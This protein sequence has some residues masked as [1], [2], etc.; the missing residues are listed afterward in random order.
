MV[1]IAVVLGLGTLVV[2][3][4]AAAVL[5]VLPTLRLQ[6]VGLALLSAVLPLAAVFGTGLVMFHMHDDIKILAVSSAS[7]LA[8]VGG[9]LLLL[10]LIHI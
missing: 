2:G 5:R 4:A 3:V 1:E 9:A 10:S 6:L 7:A 8:A